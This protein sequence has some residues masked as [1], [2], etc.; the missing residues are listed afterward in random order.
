MEITTE[1]NH[2]EIA[3]YI[4]QTVQ[5]DSII[6]GFQLII[7]Y[8]E[9]EEKFGELSEDDL[10]HIYN[11]LT[12]REE[13]ADVVMSEDDYDIVLYTDYAPN[14]SEDDYEDEDWD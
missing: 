2:E 5:E 10:S 6:S 3:N 12:E 11:L 9:L 8:D 1:I 7:T 4:V 13:V 14:Y